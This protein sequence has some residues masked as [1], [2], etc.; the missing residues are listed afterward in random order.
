MGSTGR[1]EDPC[2]LGVCSLDSGPV[3]ISCLTPGQVSLPG[4]VSSSGKQRAW[5]NKYRPGPK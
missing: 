3:L 5:K 1:M 4:S 2:S